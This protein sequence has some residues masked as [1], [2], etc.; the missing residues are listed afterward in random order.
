[1][2]VLKSKRCEKEDYLL[3]PP[4]PKGRLTH[5]VTIEK[6]PPTIMNNA[7]RR[8]AVTYSSSHSKMKSLALTKH[9]TSNR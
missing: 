7:S 1:M 4:P 2:R 8:S 6:S 3:H 5:Y 9:I